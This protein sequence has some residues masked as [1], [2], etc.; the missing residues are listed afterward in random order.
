MEIHDAA[1]ASEVAA[2]LSRRWSG[3]RD[4]PF[5]FD[6]AVVPGP[7]WQRWLSQQLATGPDG[8]CAGIE[9]T[10][11][12]SLRA[13]LLGRDDP[14]RP[15]RLAWLIQQ[16]IAEHT[17]DPQWT[18]LVSHL[19]A[20][21]ES[22][23]VTAR[24]ATQFH[25]YADLAPE[26]LQRWT[27][28]ETVGPAGEALTDHSWQPMLWRALVERTGIDPVR[29]HRQALEDLRLGPH[30]EIPHRVAVVAPA[31]LDA[32]MLEFF[33]ALGTHHSVDLLM[34]SAAPSRRPEVGAR[35]RRADVLRPP[36][37][38]LNQALGALGDENAALLPAQ[39]PVLA[40]RPDNLLG[41]LATDLLLD[42]PPAPRR[43]TPTDRSVQL[44]LSHGPSRQVEVL[45]EVLAELYRQ[46]RSLEPRHVAVI[47]PDPEGFGPLLDAAFSASAPNQAHPASG[48]RLQ[49]ADRSQTSVNPLIGLLTQLLRLPDSRAEASV[50]LQLCA[51]PAIA[52]RF[53]FT[54]EAHQRL[55]DLVSASGIRWGLG[56]TQRAEFGLGALPQNTWQAGLQRLLLGVALSEQHLVT[57]GTVLPL[58]DVDSSDVDL[59]G[60]ITEFIGRLSRWLQQLEQPATLAEWVQRCRDVLADLIELPAASEWLIADLLAGLG[61][62]AEDGLSGENAATISRR[63]AV[64]AIERHFQQTPARAAF[65]NGTTVVSGMTSLDRVPHRVV[66][67]LGWDAERYPRPDQHH[68]DDLL[69]LD[70]PIGAPSTAMADRQALLNAIQAAEQTLVIIARGRSEATNAD[71]PPATPLA[72][73]LDALNATAQTATGEPVTDVIAR[74]HPLQPF[75]PDYFRP[76]S[77]LTS[78][79]PLAYRA[80]VAWES[81]AANPADERNRYRLDRLPAP[82]LSEG[83]TVQQLI[84]FYRHPARTL[85][86]VRAG[87]SL[88]E[89]K[90]PDD[91]IP[92]E[93][94]ALERWQIGNRLLDQLRAGADPASAERAEWLRGHVPPLQL[95]HKVMS[96]AMTDALRTAADAPAAGAGQHHDVAVAIPGPNGTPI[97]VSGRVISHGR[98]L[99]QVEFSSLQPRQKLSA[100]MSLLV[101]TVAE[102]D[103]WEAMVVGR[104]RRTRLVAPPAAV[105]TDLLARYLQLYAL[106]LSRPLPA[107]PRLN[108]E[109]ASHRASARDPRSGYAAKGLRRT[110]DWESDLYWNKFFSYPEL[111]ELPAAG[112][113]IPGADPTESTLVGALAS[114]IWGPLLQAEVAP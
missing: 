113:A 31:R 44:H 84:D 99:W 16:L 61:Q 20:S 80:A 104:G 58:D 52:R 2:R 103:A 71:T 12:G 83:V 109:W 33:E 27:D 90:L 102:P 17:S 39:Q 92:I 77:N 62:L 38:P 49:L 46:D 59:I 9:F 86:K 85:F 35:R 88:A 100:W 68:G 111:L 29:R 60:A 69:R 112:W 8:I 94:D 6:L 14:W 30:P 97:A 5:G 63:S 110:W 89:E 95:G 73:V 45:R 24:I 4:D 93:P 50:V 57:V 48:F 54:V 56:P 105:A 78:V 25:G 51:E 65:G 7:G 32:G 91:Q 1:T 74:Q 34:L 3:P 42:R 15:Q 41:W 10:S 36:G 108:A 96:T 72:E 107:M 18:V 82:D 79:D 13:R 28:G 87:V 37:H 22:F 47:T 53:G 106:G 81:A 98:T 76:D 70:P 11:L 26:M 43:L 55:S 114:S 40:Q 23:S 19:N 67:L 66:V 64:A 75:A 21:H 101:L